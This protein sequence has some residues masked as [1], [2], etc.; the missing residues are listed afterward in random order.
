MRSDNTFTTNDFF[1]YDRSPLLGELAEK[2]NMEPEKR[3]NAMKTIGERGW[4]PRRYA[5]ILDVLR[6]PLR[7]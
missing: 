6:G 4:A 1:I 7:K 3:R 2:I 5:N